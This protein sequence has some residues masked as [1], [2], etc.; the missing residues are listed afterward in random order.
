MR[1]LRQWRSRLNSPRVERVPASSK[2]LLPARTATSAASALASATA[3]EAAA[4]LASVVSAMARSMSGPARSSS[5][6]AAWSLDLQVADLGDRQRVLVAV[7]GRA[8]DPGPG[9][10]AHEG[11]GVASAA[12]AM[13]ASTA[14]W[15]IC[16]I[17]PM[18][19]G[20]SNAFWWGR[21]LPVLDRPRRRWSWCRSPS[22]AGR[23]STSRRSPSGP[24][25]GARRTRSR[26]R[27]RRPWRPPAP[28]GRG[29]R[30]R[31]RTS[32]RSGRSGRPAAARASGRRAPTWC[33]S[34]RRRCRSGCP[35]GRGRRRNASAAPSP[36]SRSASTM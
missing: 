2:S 18:V 16:A 20:R 34:R 1:A 27:R 35:A 25:R 23:S 33:R 31:S 30:P 22:S 15:M 9:L 7:L 21:M 24:W 17:G 3:I 14:A 28:S 29:A 26:S 8:V 36:S 5:A 10:G 13:P 32:C 19:V 4:T 11:D 12:L 6:S